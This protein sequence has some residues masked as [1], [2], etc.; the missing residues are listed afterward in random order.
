MKN[1]MIFRN[2]LFIATLFFVFSCSKKSDEI[3]PAS[4]VGKWK[5]DGLTGKITLTDNGKAVSKD[6]KQA[7][8]NDLIEFKSDNTA[9]YYGLSLKYSVSGSILTF[10]EAN[11]SFDYTIT[12]IAGTQL[13]LSF[14]KEQYAKFA[15]LIYEPTDPDYIEYLSY[16]DKITL[17][18]YNQNY[19]KQ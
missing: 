13:T 16:K 2:L 14:T 11:V 5:F 8:T 1:L 19:V 3:T 10:S 18:E 6:L 9:V 7:A 17:F 12:K 15:S 4:F